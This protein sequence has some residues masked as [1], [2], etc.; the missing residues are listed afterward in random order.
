LFH[1][2]NFVALDSF[3][4]RLLDRSQDSVSPL[5]ILPTLLKVAQPKGSVNT[6]KNEEQFRCPATE[7]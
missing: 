1:A 6:D 4:Q 3:A 7:T 2:A 5:C